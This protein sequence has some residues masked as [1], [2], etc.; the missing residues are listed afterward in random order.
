M[1]IK[2]ISSVTSSG[3]NEIALTNLTALNAYD[4]ALFIISSR[5][6]GTTSA[7]EPI[8]PRVNSSTS[9]NAYYYANNGTA[10]TT[11]VNTQV[12]TAQYED[13]FNKA[14]PMNST[15]ANSWSNMYLYFIS[16]QTPTS[17]GTTSDGQRMYG[18]VYAPN[19]TTADDTFGLMMTWA[20]NAISDNK[21]YLRSGN[22]FLN[23]TTIYIY[24]YDRN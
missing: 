14:S 9:I 17:Q 5:S 24:G 3:T 7:A 2:F 20:P 19:N 12:N 4:G 11:G 15:T 16:G 1:G 21:L 6:G 18:E 13:L 23:G 10:G 8:Y 22:G